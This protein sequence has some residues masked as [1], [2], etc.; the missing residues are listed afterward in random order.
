MLLVAKRTVAIYE[1][2]HFETGY[3]AD[4]EENVA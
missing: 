3:G 4:E 1:S 2:T